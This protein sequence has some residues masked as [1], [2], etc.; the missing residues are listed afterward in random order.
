MRTIAEA[1][2]ELDVP[3]HVLRFWEGRFDQIRP[4][5]LAGGRRH[6]RPDDLA[7]L[8]GIRELI[9]TDGYTIKGVQKLLRDGGTGPVRERGRAA[10]GP[11]S[12]ATAAVPAR[13]VP[14]RTATSALPPWEDVEDDAPVEAPGSAV[15]SGVASAAYSGTPSPS[16]AAGLILRRALARLEDARSILDT[17]A[18]D[19][20]A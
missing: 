11:A 12:A 13:P 20:G 17:A 9:H 7:L 2:D 18:S 1:A 5:K 3:A 10:A 14:G 16:P 15:S 8:R 4:L 6:Y 19:R